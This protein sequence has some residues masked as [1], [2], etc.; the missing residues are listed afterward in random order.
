MYFTKTM[1][2]FSFF[3]TEVV[4]D[5]AVKGAKLH[6]RFWSWFWGNF[7]KSRLR[8]P[9]RQSVRYLRYC[10]VEFNTKRFWKGALEQNFTASDCA[11]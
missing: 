8:K 1:F 3:A 7:R 5:E 2:T 9:K 6:I 4:E 10:P 11:I